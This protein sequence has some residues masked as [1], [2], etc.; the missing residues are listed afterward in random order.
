MGSDAF[1]VQA[2]S[3]LLL[4]LWHHDL[5]LFLFLFL[6]ERGQVTEMSFLY[7]SELTFLWLKH[8]G[9]VNRTHAPSSQ[10]AL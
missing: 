7:H 4:K 5:L 6:P 2:R 10:G 8:W 9:L 3:Y 1:S